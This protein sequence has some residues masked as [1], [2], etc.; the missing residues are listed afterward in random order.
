MQRCLI[1]PADPK[2]ELINAKIEDIYRLEEQRI[3]SEIRLCYCDCEKWQAS[4][5]AASQVHAI[6]A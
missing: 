5:K 6:S 4:E 2:I 1:L 3:Q